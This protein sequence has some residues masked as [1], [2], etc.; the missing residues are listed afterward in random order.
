MPRRA[1][2]VVEQDA[3]EALIG[4]LDGLGVT[5]SVESAD[6]D[7]SDFLLDVAGQPFDVEV[8]S[9]V[10]AAL[11]ERL[12]AAIAKCRVAEAIGD[13]LEVYLTCRVEGETFLETVH[14]VGITP[15]KERVYA[16]HSRSAHRRESL[17]ACA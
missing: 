7:N 6:T 17:A 8:K 2:A 1:T 4:A 14:R 13:I 10:T 15:F 16:D 5:V 12:G 11:G 3:V 9:V